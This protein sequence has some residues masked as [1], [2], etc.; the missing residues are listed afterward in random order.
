MAGYFN[1]AMYDWYIDLGSGYMR[2]K[3]TAEKAYTILEDL[4]DLI[5]EE[6]TMKCLSKK[7]GE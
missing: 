1:N 7:I 4:K 2:F 5:G 3:A 6:V